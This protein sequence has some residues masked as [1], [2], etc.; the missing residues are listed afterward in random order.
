MSGSKANS[1]HS[2]SSMEYLMTYGW[3]VLIVAVAIA[4]MYSLGVFSP[5]V[6]RTGVCVPYPG[7]SCTSPVLYPNGRLTTEIGSAALGSQPVTISA[8]GCS[9]TTSAP[10]SIP[11]LSQPITL[12]T[13]GQAPIEFQ[14]PGVSTQ[15]G[16]KFTGTLWV[17]YGTSAM[18]GIV[19]PIA[20]ITAYV[21]SA[22]TQ[23]GTV[24]MGTNAPN[25]IW[26]SIASS[27]SGS[28]DV[29]A[30]SGPGNIYISNNFGGNW[31]KTSAESAVWYG[32]TASS[33]GTHII[34]VQDGLNAGGDGLGTIWHST[35]Y[36][37]TWTQSN[38]IDGYWV[39]VAS[40]STGQYGAA[41][42]NTGGVYTSNNFGANWVI[43][44]APSGDW[45]G[46]A[47][48]ANGTDLVAIIHGGDI[49]T[50]TNGG[51]T[52]SATSAPSESWAAVSSSA[53]GTHLLAAAFHGDLFVSTNSGLTWTDEGSSTYGSWAAVAS[54]F[55]GTRLVASQSGGVC[56]G[57]NIFYSIN[58]GATWSSAGTSGCWQ[59]IASSSDGTH[60]VAGRENSLGIYN[61]TGW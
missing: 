16:S 29:A 17:M 43:T 24:W 49:Y 54:S 8:I 26:Y 34:A 35:N 3:A 22:G 60:L 56:G 4:L 44:S 45:D 57:D 13:G 5:R 31:I 40:S 12:S 38:S 14:C 48:S 32:V 19:Q 18:S 36:G 47:S 53:D 1:K 52:W 55:D 6:E 61:S 30:Q 15:L 23:A 46:I 27:A 50:S 20:T 11:Y 41:V 21:Q 59:S 58:S 37:T 7:F 28:F 51:S 25:G 42:Y 2:Q 33:D 10:S 39:S 9:N